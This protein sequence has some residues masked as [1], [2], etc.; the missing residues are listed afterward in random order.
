MTRP[1]RKHPV[2]ARPEFRAALLFL[3]AAAL[4]LAFGLL[5]EEVGEAETMGFDR[6]VTAFLRRFGSGAGWPMEVARD[7]TS[8]GSVAVL[9]LVTLLAVAALLIR[10]DR[11]GAAWLF[12]TVASG[13]LLSSGFKLWFGRARPDILPL[14]HSLSASFPSGHSMLSAIAYLTIGMLLARAMPSRAARIL[15]MVAAIFIVLV[16]GLSRVYLGFHWPTD[17]LGGW[18]LGTG[19]AL[20]CGLLARR[21]QRGKDAG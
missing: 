1:A 13:Q 6:A 17:V 14:P 8:L 20:L 10:K 7:L 5:A 4:L 3:L 12:A 18:S 11:A 19:W 21:F 9:S 15:P 2:L 16:V